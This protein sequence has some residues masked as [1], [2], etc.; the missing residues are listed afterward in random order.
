MT[1]QPRAYDVLAAHLAPE[2]PIEG[3]RQIDAAILTLQRSRYRPRNRSRAAFWLG[4]ILLALSVTILGARA[5]CW[6]DPQLWHTP[7]GVLAGAVPILAAKLMFIG[8][9]VHLIYYCTREGVEDY[10]PLPLP[11]EP[12]YEWLVAH[13]KS[14]L[15]YWHELYWSYPKRRANRKELLGFVIWRKTPCPPDQYP[16]T[17]ALFQTDPARKDPHLVYLDSP[18]GRADQAAYLV[19]F[20]RRMDD[21]WRL[22]F[23]MAI[24]LLIVLIITIW[25][26]IFPESQT[27]RLIRTGVMLAFIVGSIALFCG[28]TVPI[29]WLPH[30]VRRYW[31]RALPP[32]AARFCE[33]MIARWS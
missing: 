6:L 23:R 31:F 24:A 15:T 14:D 8:A 20:E 17:P 12:I 33:H 16:P 4:Q 10:G 22:S 13:G 11:P 25:L 32:E 3:E 1:R 28:V 9:F 2:D 26:P 29:R 21:W 7:L 5:L 19:A 18:E 30:P 27:G